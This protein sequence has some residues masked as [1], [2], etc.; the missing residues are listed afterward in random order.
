MKG[1]ENLKRV[2]SLEI[3]V[4]SLEVMV[5]GY[6]LNVFRNSD[7]VIN[8]FFTYTTKATCRLLCGQVAFFMKKLGCGDG[9]MRRGR[10]RG[11]APCDGG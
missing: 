4:E 5:N 9:T 10:D 1:E 8:M 6:W 2:D 7:F 11:A 3:R